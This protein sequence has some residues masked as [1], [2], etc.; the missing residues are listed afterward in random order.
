MTR[1]LLERV[2]VSRGDRIVVRDV[3]L[4]VPS[5]AWVCLIGPNGAGKTTLLHALAALIVHTGT[6]RIGDGE[7]SRMSRRGRA[8][9]LALV[10][11][12][13]QL[14]TGLRVADYVML[15]RTPYI[16]YFGREDRNDRIVVA[17][18][19]EQLDLLGLA[20]RPLGHLSGGER[21]RVVVARA[22]A[23]LP[24]ILL[25]DEPTTALDLG[26][27]LQVLELI[28]E[29]QCARALTVISATHDLTLAAAYADRL[30]LISCGSLVA[31]GT[32]REV[33]T[34]ATLGEHYGVSLRVIHDEDGSVAVIPVR[35]PSVTPG[36]SEG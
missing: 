2:S 11:Q 4:D 9:Q 34:T 19:L 5:G 33:L 36:P 21:Q 10:Q 24:S 1:V 14:P 23:Q 3:S 26:R 18:V 22:L 20:D 7:L 27:Q 15:G 30:A 6:I 12:D 16:S 13:S 29:Q 17:E 25:L 28:R 31:E 8:Q 35:P 32:P